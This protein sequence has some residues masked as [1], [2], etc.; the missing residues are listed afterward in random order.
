MADQEHD[1]EQELVND[2]VSTPT[3]LSDRWSNLEAYVMQNKQRVTYIGIAIALVIAGYIAYNFWYLPGQEQE[4]EV[5]IFPAQRYFGIDSINK[6]IPIFQQVADDYGATKIGH[7]AN[8]YLGVCYFRKK[9]YQKAIDYLDKFNAGDIMV[10]PIA[11][12]L[13]GDAEMQLGHTDAALEDYL[14][15]CKEKR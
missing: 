14:E 15:G 4:A 7:T 9:D 10:T 13:M 1:Q 12:G 3:S 8:Y 2:E 11:A 6:A 5:A